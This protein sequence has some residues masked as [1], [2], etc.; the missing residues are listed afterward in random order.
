M[1]IL[2]LSRLH[3]A[4]PIISFVQTITKRLMSTKTKYIE[5]GKTM[6][7]LN[8]I[9]FKENAHAGL[10]TKAKFLFPGLGFAAGYKVLQRTYKFG[11][12]MT[13]SGQQAEHAKRRSM[14]HV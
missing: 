9:I 14:I 4:S 13:V 5:S 11:G 3:F 1:I 6:Q 12:Q 8:A 10:A 2:V 7:N